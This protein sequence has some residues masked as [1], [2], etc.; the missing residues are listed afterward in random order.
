MISALLEYINLEIGTNENIFN[1]KF[2]KW[3]FL[4]HDCWLKVL[5]KFCSEEN[6]QL[7]GDYTRL[8][9]QRVND[10][11]LMEELIN[12]NQGFFTKKEII[13]INRCRLYLQLIFYS[14]LA[15]SD[16]KMFDDQMITGYRD[17]Y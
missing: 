6:I 2:S 5:W 14:D 15:N 11:C 17:P 16:G 1:L 9:R 12:D 10:R 4:L 3:G 13:C 8:E 7:H